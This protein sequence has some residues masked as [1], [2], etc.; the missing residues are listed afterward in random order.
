MIAKVKFKEPGVTICINGQRM[1]AGNLTQEDYE[2]LLSWN[3]EYASH[4][5]PVEEKAEA[6]PK[7]KQDGKTKEE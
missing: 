1:H 7:L 6:R 5:E 2:Y 4:F 3:P